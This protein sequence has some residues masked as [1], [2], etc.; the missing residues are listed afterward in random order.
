MKVL[1]LTFLSLTTGVSAFIN[2]TSFYGLETSRKDFDCSWQHPMPYYVD[3]LQENGFNHY[4]I[5][6]SM[7]YI[8][9]GNFQKLDEFTEYIQKYPG[10]NFTID[11]HRIF[12][13]H[14]GVDIFE[15]G[16]TLTQ[17]VDAWLTIISRYKDHPQFY[18]I[19]VFNE[20]QLDDY[21]FWSSTMASVILKIEDAVP[22]RLHYFVGGWK[23]GGSLYGINLEYLPFS[24]RIWYTIHKYI[25][26]IP[27]GD[28]DYEKDWETSFYEPIRHKIVVGEWGFKMEVPE[29]VEW[30]K[31]FITWLKNNNIRNSF[32]WVAA[33]NS[34]D[35][36]ALWKTDC[37]TFEYDK[38]QVVKSLW[39][40]GRDERRHFRSKRL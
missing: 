7:E 20:Y 33:G 37:E 23:W 17:F 3:L 26:S 9:E 18:G 12:A 6:V 32:F 1:S 28:T 27:H 16:T 29:Q 31:R 10:T 14:Q 24:D 21:V 39:V 5:P 38:V 4:R 25:F 34:G 11:M 40:D 22:N 8:Q 2:G 30:A 13:S 36:N 15:A 35:T 19:D